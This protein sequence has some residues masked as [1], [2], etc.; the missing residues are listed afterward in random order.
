M[1]QV[2]PHWCPGETNGP[3]IL[4]SVKK[5]SRKRVTAAVSAPRAAR[6][7]HMFDIILIAIG[8]GFFALSVGY[9]IAC[10]RL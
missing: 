5:V 1:W 8:L 3:R 2:A 6:S 9:T 4:D 10:D 7:T